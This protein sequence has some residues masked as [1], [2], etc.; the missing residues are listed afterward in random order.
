MKSRKFA[1][2][3]LAP[4]LHKEM[5]MA[6]YLHY[7]NTTKEKTNYCNVLCSYSPFQQHLQ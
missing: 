2:Y 5:S 7:T 6:I 3:V 1:H 4:E